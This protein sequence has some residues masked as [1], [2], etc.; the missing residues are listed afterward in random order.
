[1][2]I[3]ALREAVLEA[4]LELLEAFAR[5]WQAVAAEQHPSLS[6]FVTPGTGSPEL[7]VSALRVSMTRLPA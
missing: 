3:D 6:R 5:T 7:D 2:T 4:N 1:V